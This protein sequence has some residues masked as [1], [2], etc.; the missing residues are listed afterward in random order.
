MAAWWLPNPTGASGALLHSEKPQ[1]LE[2]GARCVLVW[3]SVLTEAFSSPPRANGETLHLPS[4][5]AGGAAQRPPQRGAGQDEDKGVQ[6]AESGQS[7]PRARK[8]GRVHLLRPA[9][10]AQ[11]HTSDQK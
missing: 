2:H 7:P 11:L 9:R 8:S 6:E 4:A 5:S 3:A 1:T 10:T